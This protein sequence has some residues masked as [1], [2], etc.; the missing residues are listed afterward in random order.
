[1]ASTWLENTRGGSHEEQR[2]SSTTHVLL[3]TQNAAA[4]AFR[5]ARCPC[6]K[7]TEVTRL[8]YPIAGIMSS[9]C[10]YGSPAFVVLSNKEKAARASLI[11]HR[12]P[13]QCARDD[14]LGEASLNAVLHWF[15]GG[16]TQWLSTTSAGEPLV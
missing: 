1:M 3:P 4:V 13:P 12:T 2:A 15:L 6:R 9:T 8:L 16:S 14:F 10:L 5:A 11:R 7:A